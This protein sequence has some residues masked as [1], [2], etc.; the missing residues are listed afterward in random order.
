[1]VGVIGLAGVDSSSASVSIS[2]SG[3]PSGSTVLGA[4]LYWDVVD[5]YPAGNYAS[6]T[7]ASHSITGTLL[8]GTASGDDPCYTEEDDGTA[9]TYV[10]GVTS[11]V[12]G[13]GAYAISE[14]WTL[15]PNPDL[16]FADGLGLVVVYSNPTL[17]STVIDLADGFGVTNNV[18]YSETSTLSLSPAASGTFAQTTY[19]IG[20]AQNFYSGDA[21]IQF[22]GTTVLSNSYYDGPSSSNNPEDPYAFFSAYTLDVTSLVPSGTTSVSFGNTI[23]DDCLVHMAQVFQYAPTTVTSPTL[24]TSLSDSTIQAGGSVTDT[25]TLSGVGT[26]AG[27]AITFYYSTSDVCPSST[28]TVVGSPFSV[29][30]PGKYGPSAS[31]TFSSPGTYYWYATYDPTSGPAITSPCEPLTV[32]TKIISSPEFGAP[33]ML[34]AA[35]G[36]LGVALLGRKLRAFPRIQAYKVNRV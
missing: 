4:F 31:Q 12:T 9:P 21:N 6:L 30:G 19:L 17:P 2:I 28:A 15:V 36:L 14:G 18:F 25:A 16:P 35:L 33:A 3:I 7:F 10:A 22:Q 8:G 32:T 29:S 20:D 1:M 24:T 27:G 11:Y 5:N 26:S 34:V 23:N 13:N